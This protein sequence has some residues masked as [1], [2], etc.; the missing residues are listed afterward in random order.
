MAT[1]VSKTGAEGALLDEAKN[2]NKSLSALGNVISS[3]ADGNVSVA[4]EFSRN[5]PTCQLLFFAAQM[6]VNVSSCGNSSDNKKDRS[7]IFQNSLI[8]LYDESFCC[9]FFLTD[10][11]HVDCGMMLFRAVSCKNLISYNQVALIVG[12]KF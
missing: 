4:A 6:F 10:L 8:C 12:D 11:C 1:Q 7:I 3:L 2:I 9:I 5:F